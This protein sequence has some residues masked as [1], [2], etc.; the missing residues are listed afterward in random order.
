MLVGTQSG[1][2]SLRSVTLLTLIAVVLALGAAASIA[3]FLGQSLDLPALLGWAGLLFVQA[4]YAALA[5]WIAHR[6]A[7]PAP[8]VRAYAWRLQGQALAEILLTLGGSGA[9]LLFFAWLAVD[10]ASVNEGIA[11]MTHDG[12]MPRTVA[13]IGLALPALTALIGLCRLHHLACAK[14]ALA[15]AVDGTLPRRTL[16]LAADAAQVHEALARCLERL[17]DADTPGLTRYFY[18]RPRVMVRRQGEDTHY[19]L[20]WAN[21]ASKVTVAASALDERT[22]EVVV[23]CVL[24]GGFYKLYWFAGPADALAQMQYMEAHVLQP[25][26]AQ[27]EKA[28]A[29][30]QRDA[31]RD[32]AIEA[33]LRIL[34]AQIEPHFLFNSL[35]NVRHLYRSSVPEGERM[36]D[37]LIAYLRSAMEDLRADY[38]T[39]AREMDLARHYLSIMQVRMGERLAYTFTLPDH[40]TDHAFPPAMLISLV[41]NAIKHGLAD[42]ERGRIALAAAIDGACLRLTV[43][44]DGR[45]FSSVGGT[46]VGLS[47]IRR[48]LE[49]MYGNRAWLEVGAPV[50]GGFAA[51]IVL[52]LDPSTTHQQ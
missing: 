5:S 49:A 48:R 44:D 24:R 34:Q 14:G 10:E 31:L 35:A 42:C 6:A 38:S 30:R 17:T 19:D 40:L 23:R 50:H 11:A 45:G 2:V 52:P 8:P 43:T 51:T 33:Q 25:L 18:G 20:L 29:E 9:I 15:A 37:H 47:N 22:Q 21:C 16:R 26:R 1:E 28:A 41:E 7:I 39:V 46:G 4:V 27:L 3:A 32:Q 13:G 36:L 12:P